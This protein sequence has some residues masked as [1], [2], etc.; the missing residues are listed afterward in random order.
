MHYY[1][2]HIKDYRARTQGLS[3]LGHGIYTTLLESYYLQEKPFPLDHQEIYMEIGAHSND[4]R[5]L[6]DWILKKYFTVID[7]AYHQT[8]CDEV[9]D[10]YH[11]NAKTKRDNGSKGG[12]PPK[13]TDDAKTKSVSKQNRDETVTGLTINHEPLTSKKNI[14][15]CAI[16]DAVNY[17]WEHGTRPKDPPTGGVSKPALK[18][19]GKK[20]ATTKLRKILKA[21][22]KEIEPLVFVKFLVEDIRKRFELGTF[23]IENLHPATYISQ[24]RWEDE[25]YENLRSNSGQRPSIAPSEQVSQAIMG[26]IDRGRKKSPDDLDRDD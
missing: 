26:A 7:D 17:F 24:E 22:P 15:Q 8:H 20:P 19:V 6:V 16:D 12:R 23:G 1:K 5:Q 4:E 18:R 13:E 11:R 10:K 2:R 14:H 21:L 9:L 25:P 3:L